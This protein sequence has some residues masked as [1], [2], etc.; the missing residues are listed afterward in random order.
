MATTY[1]AIPQSPPPTLVGLNEVATKYVIT[2]SGLVV[3]DVVQFFQM[4]LGACVIDFS[5]DLPALDTNVSPATRISVGTDLSV[6][7]GGL[8]V[9]GIITTSSAGT[10]FSAATVLSKVGNVN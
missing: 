9:G 3:N 6:A 7:N 5:I 1:V 10:S 4:P 2:S 8:D